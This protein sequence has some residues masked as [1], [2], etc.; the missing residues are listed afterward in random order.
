MI[1][2]VGPGSEIAAQT[3]IGIAVHVGLDGSTHRTVV[4]LMLDHIE[5]IFPG[6]AC[7][8]VAGH[9]IG[10][11]FKKTVGIGQSRIRLL[12]RKR[13]IRIEYTQ[14][15]TEPQSV[16][17][18]DPGSKVSAED[19]VVVSNQG[20]SRVGC[21]EC[22][23]NGYRRVE[24]GKEGFV[25]RLLGIV[26]LMKLTGL[27]VDIGNGT[28]GVGDA[29]HGGNL[30]DVAYRGHFGLAPTPC[31]ELIPGSD[32]THIGIPEHSPVPA[33]GG[34]IVLVV[35]N[36][37]GI[38]G[39]GVAGKNIA[40]Q[41][42]NHLIVAASV[43]LLSCLVARENVTGHLGQSRTCGEIVIGEH[44]EGSLFLI[45]VPVRKILGTGNRCDYRNDYND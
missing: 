43:F 41:V 4:E 32:Q 14:G 38:D 44:L 36:P 7:R 11:R 5:W 30:H 27:E 15:K 17:D 23:Q 13:C 2:A 9:Y 24:L 40:C 8:T 20:D 12:L 34:N 25:N 31:I 45:G 42:F 39:A 3:G 35:V 37:T 10:L 29:V 6:S 26:L 18:L 1:L 21:H 28:I 19:I 33:A 16:G 22:S